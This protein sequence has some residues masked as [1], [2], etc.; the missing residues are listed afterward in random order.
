MEEETRRPG[1][2]AGGQRARH[3]QHEMRRK[4]A[5][6]VALVLSLHHVLLSTHITCLFAGT[7][8]L[9]TEPSFRERER[10]VDRLTWDG[11]DTHWFLQRTQLPFSE[12]ERELRERKGNL[13]IPSRFAETPLSF[14]EREETA[15]DCE[16]EE[17]EEDH[18][19]SLIA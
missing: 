19:T 17:E 11:G 14:S 9:L 1:A 6:T 3:L 4:N 10:Q 12:T 5:T 2:H 8:T 13:E 18:R 7:R 16:E 15:C